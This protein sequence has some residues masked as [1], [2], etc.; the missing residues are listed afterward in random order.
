ME[1]I[2]RGLTLEYAKEKREKLLAELKSD[3]H[4]NQTETVAYGHHDPLSVP[5]AV[6]DSCH[7]RAQMQKVIGSPV[8][9]NM[10]CLVCGKTIPQHRKRPW[11]AAI[12]WNQINLGTQDYRQLPLFGL[13]SLSPESARQK[14]V[15]IRRNLELRKSLAGI[16][17]TIAHRE[18]QRPPGKEYQQRLEAYL[19]WAMLALRLLK[20]KAS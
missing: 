2:R 19:Q 18:G 9:W 4:Y 14:M 1:E 20:V 5:V 15:G 3:E 16:E 8:R 6:C 10:V 11:Q 12:A 13:G 7:G 17:R